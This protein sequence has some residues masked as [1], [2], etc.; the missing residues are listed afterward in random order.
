MLPSEDFVSRC[1]QRLVVVAG[2]DR[3]ATH[4]KRL[5]AFVPS[6]RWPG[7]HVVDVSRDRTR[8]W[9]TP[10][11]SFD[12][13]TIAASAGRNWLERPIGTE[14]RGIWTLSLD[15]RSRKRLTTPPR[16]STDELPIWAGTSI[17]F[18]RSGP[19][20]ADG[21]ASGALYLVK[22]GGT[23][24]GPLA[25]LGRTTNFYGHYARSDRIDVHR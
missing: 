2:P 11:C 9:V 8:S 16:G 7:W 1:G 6:T 12:G 21:T 20:S 23:V 3:Y 19:T 24:T 17:L 13:R 4:D 22:P 14:A 25:K 18:V 5:V 10:A 15:G